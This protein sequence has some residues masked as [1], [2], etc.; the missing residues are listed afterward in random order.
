MTNN[1]TQYEIE[2]KFFVPSLDGWR[3]RVL[4]AGAQLKKPRIFEQ[5]VSYDDADGTLLAA[6]S[7]L[8]LRQDSAIRLTWKGL[9]PTGA[10]PSESKVREELEVGVTDFAAADAILKRLGYQPRNS[11]EKYRE[12]F[13][14]DD[15]EIVI[16][17]L[18]FGNFIELEGE[19]AAIRT[20]AKQLGLSWDDRLVASYLGLLS[21]LNA[22]YGTATA[23]LTFA[24]FADGRRS[25][26]AIL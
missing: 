15:V 8:R 26:A 3:G 10:T 24:N 2:V 5:N 6:K 22:H 9:P 17:E 1:N 25:V 14:L 20:A 18:P 19:E 13:Q 11:Y 12:T 23:D 16:D 4:A 21:Q 7:L